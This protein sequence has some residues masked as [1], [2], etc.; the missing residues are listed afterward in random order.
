MRTPSNTESTTITRPPASSQAVTELLK[1]A[2]VRQ[3]R[4]SNTAT[5]L[6]CRADGRR[7][8]SPTD[9]V[10]RQASAAD[11]GLEVRDRAFLLL[12]H[13]A[14]QVADR[15]HPDHALARHHGQVANAH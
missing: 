7:R 13:G 4:K 1:I 15:E 12:D 10:R 2:A 14:H 5:T 11:V 3:S 8:P 9:T 6:K